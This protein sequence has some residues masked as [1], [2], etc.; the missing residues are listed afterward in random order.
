[1]PGRRVLRAGITAGAVA[2]CLLGTIPAAEAAPRSFVAASVHGNGAGAVGAE[3]TGGITWHNR[4]VTLT[5]VRL[6]VAARECGRFNIVAWQGNRLVDS[7][8]STQQCAGATG[9]W[10]PYGDLPL[11]GSAI[12]GGITE[13]VIDVYDD[14]HTGNGYADC[15]RS[16]SS[17]YTWPR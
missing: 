3:T 4:S 14:T 13:V 5:S 16:G 2:A 10:I 6:Y 9:R 11:D 8:A 15:T 7:I 1:M 12:A 17:C